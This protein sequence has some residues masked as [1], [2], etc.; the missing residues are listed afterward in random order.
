MNKENKITLESRLKKLA[1]EW[2]FE[3]CSLNLQTNQNPLVI[4]IFMKKTN[5]DDISLDDC[6]L[7]NTPASEEIDNSNLINC[8]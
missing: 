5:G 2:N 8:S 3:I 4:E 7:F 1:N 6:V